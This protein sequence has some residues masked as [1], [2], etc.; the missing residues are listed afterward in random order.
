M[1]KRNEGGGSSEESKEGESRLVHREVSCRWS[2]TVVVPLAQRA[3][4]FVGFR[5][6]I[7]WNVSIDSNL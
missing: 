1:R 7:K 5:G 2:A 6:R 3:G 4:E